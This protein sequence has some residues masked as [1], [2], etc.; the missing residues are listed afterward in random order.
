MRIAATERWRDETVAL[1]LLQPEAV[2]DAYIG[3]LND[4]EINRYLESRFQP[5]DRASVEAFVAA[6]LASERDLFLAIT[7]RALG[8]HVGNIK[9]GPID[10][11]HGL[12][13]IG[14]MIG[15]RAAWGRGIGARAIN[16]IVGI[17]RHEL[18]LRRL[19]AGCYASNVG[20]RKAFE[21][22]GFAVEAV[23]PAHYLLDGA[24]EDAVLM[25]RLV[26]G[27]E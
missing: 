15:D 27:Q 22:A 12:G 26:E 2:S 7:D 6:M 21:K 14:I 10:R 25:G 3:W 24:P 9:L 18:G 1:S 11:A 20:S 23:R 19:T 16:L 8:R 13:E 17:A 5:Q 4:P